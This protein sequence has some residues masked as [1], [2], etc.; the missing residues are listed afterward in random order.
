[1]D[2]PEPLT[3]QNISRKM[4]LS[5]KLAFFTTSS[6]KSWSKDAWSVLRLVEGLT[7]MRSRLKI[8]F[9]NSLTNRSQLLTFTDNLEKSERL[10]PEVAL[11]KFMQPLSK[12]W[13]LRPCSWSDQKL[14]E[15][16]RSERNL[17]QGPICPWSTSMS[18]CNPVACKIPTTKQ[19]FLASFNASAQ[20]PSHVLFWRISHKMWS[21]RSISWET[22]NSHLTF[23]PCSARKTSVKRE[24]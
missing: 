1:M 15:K 4:S 20:R 24:C 5:A 21:R 2:S 19:L 12:L 9:R 22:A 13:C 17:P 8:E 11:E 18:L 10:M 3:R 14:Q 23:S 16:L 6:R 7:T